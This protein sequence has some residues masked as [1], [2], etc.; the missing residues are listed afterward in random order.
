[1]NK[2][3]AIAPGDTQNT[4]TSPKAAKTQRITPETHKDS[5]AAVA[6]AVEEKKG[7]EEPA[8]KF[9]ATPISPM[10][11]M[12]AKAEAARAAKEAENKLHETENELSMLKT[13]M[14]MLIKENTLLKQAAE[15]ENIEGGKKD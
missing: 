8:K 1:L 12:K 7:I 2:S 10:L 14:E 5:F 6:I 4:S 13:K 15:A 11:V 3:S 9:K